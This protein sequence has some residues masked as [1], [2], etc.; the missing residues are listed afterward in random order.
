MTT[1]FVVAILISH[2]APLIAA[3]AVVS[4]RTPEEV[5]F[6]VMET[7]PAVDRTQPTQ[8]KV[9][10]GD[11]TVVPLA[12][13]VGAK[14]ASNTVNY[15]IQADA[16]YYFGELPSGKI[17]LGRIGIGEMPN[18][19]PQ[20]DLLNIPAPKNSPDA[21]DAARTI[22]VKIFVDEKE[23]EKP[24]AWQR[25]LRDRVAAASDILQRTCGMRLKVID[26][27]TWQSEN[28][29]KFE[30]A[31]DEFARKTDPGEARIAIGFTSQFQITKGRTHLG[32]TRGPLNRHI[33]LREWSQYVTEPERLELLVH[34]I[35]HFLGAVHSPEPDSVM[36]V[37]LG[38]KQARARKFQIHFDPLNTLAMN[39]VAEQW[40]R[41]PL[42]SYAE[43]SP[44][45]QARLRAIYSAISQTLPDDASSLQYLRI[46]DR[47]SA[48][49]IIIA[50]Q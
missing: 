18:L 38:D 44:Q 13:G 14:L 2:V 10:P 32:G 48:P 1:L 21:D 9:A 41:H 34:E 50:P 35:G 30:D 15:D 33:L 47:T 12:R 20:T 43:L 49:R 8:Y 11:L 40:H 22:T 4:N 46:L 39:L 42:H 27:G 6:S 17:D 45:T 23:P 24:A 7:G 26:T 25:R 31:V 28:I 29:A 37:I 5:T 16:A 3:V 36:R 19:D